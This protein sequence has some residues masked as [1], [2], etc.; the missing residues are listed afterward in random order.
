[1]TSKSEFDPLNVAAALEV[2]DS[3]LR[4]EFAGEDAAQALHLLKLELVRVIIEAQ[5]W[6][7]GR[8]IPVECIPAPPEQGWS[9]DQCRTLVLRL[10]A[11]LH[12]LGTLAA[13]AP[14]GPHVEQGIADTWQS[15]MTLQGETI[16][17]NDDL[18]RLESSRQMTDAA[19]AAIRGRTASILSIVEAVLQDLERVRNV[20]P[21]HH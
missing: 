18:D 3:E 4:D 19:G 2:L 13:L 12:C 17:L 7:E 16:Q 1:M 21:V 8:N 15:L 5:A 20:E 6:V 10:A 9:A 14:A 11:V